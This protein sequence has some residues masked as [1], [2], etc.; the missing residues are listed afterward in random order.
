MS[1]VGCF[2]NTELE[3]R[4]GDDY[5]LYKIYDINKAG[6][7]STAGLK[8]D[9]KKNFEI[10]AQNSDDTLVLSLNIVEKST[11]KSVFK[12]SVAQYRVI[13]VKN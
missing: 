12:K 3:I 5:R 1:I 9:L 4:S 7:E 6:E 2:S 13:K 10:R 8:I 11:G